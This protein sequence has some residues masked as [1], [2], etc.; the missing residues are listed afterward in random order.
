[1]SRLLVPL[2]G[3]ALLTHCATAQIRPGP[4]AHVAPPGVATASASG[5][6]VWVDGTAW[7]GHPSDLGD[8]LSP[9]Y[10]A[11]ENH[12]GRPIRVNHGEFELIGASGFHYAPLSLLSTSRRLEPNPP[13]APSSPPTSPPPAKPSTPPPSTTPPPPPSN[14]PPP[15]SNAPPA[16][17]NPST[18]PQNA[19]SAPDKAGGSQINSASSRAEWED[20]ANVASALY[21]PAVYQPAVARVYGRHHYFRPAFRPYVSFY[22]GPNWWWY[23]Y[24]YPYSYWGYPYPYYYQ[25]PIPSQDMVNQALPEGVVEDGG[26]VAGFLYF[27]RVVGRE[28]RLRFEAQFADAKTNEIVANIKVPLAV[29]R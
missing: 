25:V 24:P 20:P 26:R 6:Q 10:V 13:N 9:I 15:P 27:P 17:D 19:P 12:S 2:L 4:G 29:T 28:T 22:W 1:M 21:Q 23:P 5:I 18:S 14:P 16:V 3:I 7:K 8:V 11:I